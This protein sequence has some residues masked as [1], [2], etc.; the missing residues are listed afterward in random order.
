MGKKYRMI[1]TIGYSNRS[2]NEF[3][4]EIL[5][6]EIS[7][8]IDV[9]SSPRSRNIQYTARKIAEWSAV[10]SLRYTQEG[11]VLGG[12]S[13]FAIDDKEYENALKRVISASAGTNV[14][15]F[16]AEGE[17]ENCHRCYDV[18]ATLLLLHQ[19]RSVQIRRN[20]TAEDVVETLRK[21]Q[22]SRFRPAL[23]VALDH[24]GGASAGSD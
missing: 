8:I 3:K 13:N 22:G 12:R 10:C 11:D 1:Y 23:R 6:R 18:A 4:H 20:G 17:P 2:L 14:A 5:S 7:H 24:F 21:V 19:T 9:R 15:I 16:C